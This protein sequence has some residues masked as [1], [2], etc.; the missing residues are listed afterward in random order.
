MRIVRL[1]LDQFRV[2]QRLELDLSPGGL[3]ISGRN[4]SGKTSLIESIAFAST[5]RSPRSRADRETVRWDSGVA[6]GVPPYARIEAETANTQD[7]HHVEISLE[8]Q[9]TPQGNGFRK[10]YRL[11]GR[12]SRA[13]EVVGIIKTVLFSPEDVQLISG[14]PA[15]RRRHADILLSQIDRTYLSALANY[16]RV[17]SHRNGLLR[18]FAKDRVD[19]RSPRASNE[20]GFWDQ[21]LIEHGAYIVAQRE[22][23]LSLLATYMEHR[24]QRL[25][26]RV[27]LAISYDS[28]LPL[29][30]KPDGSMPLADRV[31]Q[32]R[33]AYAQELNDRRNEEFRRGVTVVGPHRDDVTFLIDGRDLAAFGSRGQQRLAVIAYK[34]A[35]SDLITEATGERPILL[36]DDVLSELD[37]V[38]RDMLLEAVATDTS[39]VIVTSTD[40]A[41]LDHPALSAIP[42]ATVDS[43]VLTL[44]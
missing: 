12:A 36:L 13:H 14:P 33:S 35:E 37:S 34:L 21:Q 9:D 22:H 7:G 19:I 42:M 32:V 44:T 29:P 25:I 28:R 11:D 20:L 24:S 6:Y 2:Y 1:T 5:T 18:A 3:R 10:R 41:L 30:G 43:G 38:H 16:G 23:F 26:D 39:Q 27:S 4:A 8:Q 15:E 40:V 31:Q 17:L